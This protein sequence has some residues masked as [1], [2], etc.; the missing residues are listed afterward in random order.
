MSGERDTEQLRRRCENC[1]AEV[2]LGDAFCASCGE[3]LG[4]AGRDR[5]DPYAAFAP[6]SESGA[7]GGGGRP[8]PEGRGGRGYG[9]SAVAMGALVVGFLVLFAVAN[10]LDEGGGWVVVVFGVPVLVLSAVFLVVWHWAIGE[11]DRR[12][13]AERD[14]QE[15]E[16]YL[17]ELQI[18]DHEGRR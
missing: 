15:R 5:D 8:A 11:M 14:R 6:V 9:C 2:G 13:K 10:G 4:E 7:R 3:R 1:R 17:R 16:D 18:R 12:N